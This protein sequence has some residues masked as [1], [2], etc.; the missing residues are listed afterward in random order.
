MSYSYY[1][2]MIN[3]FPNIDWI[4]TNSIIENLTAK[5]SEEISSL[6]TAIDITDDVF[7]KIIP[8]IKVELLK[9]MFPQEFLTCLK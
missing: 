4:S 7:K 9:N 5:D 2:S 6:Q 8:E 3:Q 1:D